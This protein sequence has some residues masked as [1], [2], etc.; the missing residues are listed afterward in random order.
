M[1]MS[2]DLEELTLSSQTV[3]EGKILTLRV[4]QVRLNDGTEAT[5]EII[6]H[7]PAVAI[8][9]IQSDN[10]LIFVRQFRQATKQVL[11]EVPAGVVDSNEAPLAAAKRELKEETGFTASEWIPLNGAYMAPGFCEE[12]IHIFAAKGLAAGDTDWDSDERIQL[13]PLSVAIVDEMIRNGDLKDAKS[14]LAV[15]LAERMG[16]L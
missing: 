16:C 15:L 2:D 7:A 8:L 4:D 10:T 14:I 12:F 3:F 9:P 5:R 13:A 1:A 11:L 6:G